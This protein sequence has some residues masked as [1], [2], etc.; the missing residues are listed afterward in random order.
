MAKRSPRLQFSDEERAA[1]ELKKAVRKADKRVDKLEKAEA[2]IP[3]K[4]V[5]VRT[6]DADTG[7]VTARISFEDKKRPPSKL[8]HA[9]EAAPGE[10]V[11]AAVHREIRQREDDNVGVESAHKLEETAE[12]GYRLADSAHRSHQLKPYRNAERAEAKADRANIRA[13]NKEAERQNPQLSSNP[14]SRWQQKQAI[15]KE[16]AAA[17]AGKSAQNTVKASE[18]TAKAASKAAETTKK[19]GEFIARHKKTFLIIGGIAAMLVLLLNVASSCSILFEGGISA[20]GMSTYPSED[21]DM[22]SA[23][24]AYCGMEAELQEHLD[25]Y[26]RTHDYDEY[27]YDLDDIE[28]DP[29]VLISA[30]TALHGGEWTVDEVGGILQTLFDKQYILTETVRT[31]RRYYIET[32]TWTETDPETGETTTYSESYRV[33]YDYYICTVELENFNLSHVPVYI[34]SQSQLSMYA[35]YMG[36]LGNRPDL[37]PSSGYISKYYTNRPDDH[38]IPEEYLSDE[39]FAAMMLEAEKYLGYPY[40]WGGSSPSTSFD[41]SGFVSWVINHSGWDV[42]RLGAQGLCN[43]CTRVSESEVKPGDLVF[44][45]GTYDTP[46]V[47]H[48]AIYCG[49]GWIIH[50]GDPISYLH[51]PSSG[52]QGNFYC[53]GRLPGN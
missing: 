28:H 51:L 36:T 15:K 19:T 29:Y 38:E 21:A 33:Y 48:V 2:K 49:D 18:A 40:V 22:R 5:K 14:Y 25:T 43:I 9:I 32:D 10:T 7:K 26:E 24:A 34:M 23:E 11:L 50:A 6:V 20:I 8:T 35:L 44:F 47:S 4:K 52:L 1:P 31:E 45:V 46:G 13:L 53:Y 12:G 16:Y 41:C 17:K 42:G 37:F 39:T 27:H 30:I 3:Q